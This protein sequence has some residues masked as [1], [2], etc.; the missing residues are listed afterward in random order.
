MSTS[1]L[2][3]HSP[4]NQD[5][6]GSVNTLDW[7]T[8]SEKLDQALAVFQKRQKWLPVHERVGILERTTRLMMKHH[9]KLA[10]QISKEGGKPLKD[11]LVETTRAIDGVRLAIETIRTEAGH[12]VPMSSTVAA[13]NKMA[14]TQL[15]PIGVVVAVSAFNH[16]LNLIVHQVASAV[17][18][19]CPVLVKPANDTPLSCQ[20]FVELLIEAGLPEVWCQCVITKDRSVAEALVTDPRVSFFSFIGSPGVGWSL[21]SKLAPGT[22]CS[23]EHGGAAPVIL[24]DTSNLQA[25]VDAITKGGFYHAGQVCVSVQRVYVHEAIAKDFLEVF[26]E[27]VSQL[28]V[29]DPMLMETDVGPLIR[30]AEVTR[31][32]NWIKEAIEQGADLICGGATIGEQCYAPTILLN[33]ATQSTVSQQE[34][35]GP[36]VCVYT[37]K[38]IDDAIEQANALPFAF[39]AAVF[40]TELA[41]AMYCYKH[42]NASAVMVNDHS[43]F[44]VDNM[45]FAG[46]KQSG[47]GVGGIQHTIR[48]MQIEKMLV[49][50]M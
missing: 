15:E 49:L 10:M 7:P 5:N 3:I 35:F 45:P 14:M 1:L 25:T 32:D 42:L 39:Q 31:V 20:N 40:T 29:G 22:R 23:L 4:Y 9:A 2:K 6:L 38:S 33:P 17:A 16:P 18:A 24:N 41:T 8:L 13:A 30:A 37:Y 28:K 11:A 48:D 47:L 44:R 50:S 43:A 26:K 36:V 46:L 34:I 12:V 27:T 21:R 19:G